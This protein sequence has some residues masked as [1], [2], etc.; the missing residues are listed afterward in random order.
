M[1]WSAKALGGQG[2]RLAAQPLA[3]PQAGASGQDFGQG[4]VELSGFAGRKIEG[5]GQRLQD[6]HILYGLRLGG[7][8][9]G[10]ALQ[11]V[12]SAG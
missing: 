7:D 6:A 2:G 10:A 12:E 11:T 9:W 3:G 4:G 1:P 5:N 8:L